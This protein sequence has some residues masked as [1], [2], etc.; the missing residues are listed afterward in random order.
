M[1]RSDHESSFI[2]YPTIRQNVLQSGHGERRKTTRESAIRNL[3]CETRH[4][5][6]HPPPPYHVLPAAATVTV[7]RIRT[8][9]RLTSS[10]SSNGRLTGAVKGEGLAQGQ[11]FAALGFV[12]LY[13]SQ[14]PAE[15]GTL[16]ATPAC[17]VHA[18]TLH[19]AKTLCNS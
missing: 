14:C 18:I 10:T 17:S 4:L 1:S 13:S 11:P 8:Q 5:H 15:Q 9:S 3:K 6:P 2:S 16:T 19:P 7:A 12:S